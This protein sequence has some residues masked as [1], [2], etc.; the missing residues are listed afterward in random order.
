MRDFGF[1]LVAVCV[2]IFTA[3]IGHVYHLD[4]ALI[5]EFIFIENIFLLVL[6]IFIYVRGEDP[7]LGEA[8][9]SIRR[10]EEAVPLFKAILQNAVSVLS[11]RNAVIRSKSL[12]FLN[13]VNVGLASLSSGLVDV[14]LR[15]G[16]AFFR[17]LHAGGHAKKSYCATTCAEPSSYWA[18]TTGKNLLLRNRQAVESGVAVKR[19]FIHPAASLAEL[20]PAMDAN[21]AAGVSVYFVDSDSIETRLVRDFGI[22]D[23]GELAVEL[24]LDA[25]RHP[26]RVRFYLS[27][28]PTADKEIRDLRK[29]WEELFALSRPVT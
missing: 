27:G 8:A 16:G 22:C 24:F 6:Q 25:K 10:F 2:S 11:N 15:P 26:E 4:V 23:D 20:R 17:E 28:V 19:I 14:D 7:Y 13:E 3:V 5:I 1:A 21:K 12:D 18:R 29:V 9:R